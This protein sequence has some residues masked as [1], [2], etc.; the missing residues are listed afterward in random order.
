MNQGNNQLIQP[1]DLSR[2]VENALHVFRQGNHD[3]LP[4]LLQDAG[5]LL[6]KASKKLTPTQLVLAVAAVAV[7]TI[8]VV[9][10]I[11]DGNLDFHNQAA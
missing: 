9:S 1:E 8:F 4:D 5:N 3:K 10:Q 7:A 11:E 2:T 6:Y